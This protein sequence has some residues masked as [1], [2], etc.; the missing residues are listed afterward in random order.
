MINYNEPGLRAC[1]LTVG[2]SHEILTPRLASRCGLRGSTRERW[3][4]LVQLEISWW[5]ERCLSLTA[6]MK[7]NRLGAYA[8]TGD[9]VE[10]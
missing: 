9:D 4:K 5:A 6:T 1:L 2:F 10:E 3:G 7:F 8:G